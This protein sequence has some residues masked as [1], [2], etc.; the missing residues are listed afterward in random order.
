MVTTLQRKEFYLPHCLG[1]EKSKQ[2]GTRSR[3]GPLAAPQHGI[4]VQ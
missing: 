1:D 2:N 3:E 4:M